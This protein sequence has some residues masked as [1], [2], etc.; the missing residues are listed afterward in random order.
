MHAHTIYTDREIFYYYNKNI[1][2][3]EIATV[4]AT[5]LTCPP[6]STLLVNLVKHEQTPWELPLS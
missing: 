6:I 1:S 3:R 4:R 5:L 2:L